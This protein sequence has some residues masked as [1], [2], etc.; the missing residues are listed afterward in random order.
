[1]G[2]GRSEIQDERHAE[3]GKDEQKGLPI[4]LY[5]VKAPHWGM[6]LDKPAHQV[7]QDAG[8]SDGEEVAAGEGGPND[9][10]GKEFLELGEKKD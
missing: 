9:L 2:L 8:S 5:G 3:P 7:L 1:M 6:S 10:P 4:G